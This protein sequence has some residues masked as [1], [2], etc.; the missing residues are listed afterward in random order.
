MSPGFK[1][2][3]ALL[4][5]FVIVG[6]AP[7]MCTRSDGGKILQRRVNL[8]SLQYAV[9]QYAYSNDLALP[10]DLQT[11]HDAGFVTDMT[12]FTIPG[13]KQ[14]PG[15]SNAIN[16]W[17]AYLYTPPDRTIRDITNAAALVLIREKPEALRSAS[18]RP[19]G[20]FLDGHTESLEDGKHADGY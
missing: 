2:S 19:C 11:L 5:L 3:I 8:R 16:S 18:Q 9:L 14:A 13:T 4:V 17:S 20:M 15:P 7:L 6:L 1:I 10:P 12:W